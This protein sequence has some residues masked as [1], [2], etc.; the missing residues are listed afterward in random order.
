MSDAKRKTRQELEQQLAQVQSRLAF[1]EANMNMECVTEVEQLREAKEKMGLASMIVEKSPAVLFRR[2]ADDTFK[3]VYV[4]ENLSQW[5]YSAEDF[6]SGKHS[7]EDIVVAADN[8]R[9]HDEIMRYAELDVEEYTQEY[10]IRTA[11][12]QLRWVS[13]ETSV[14]RDE[15]GRRIFNQGVMLDI[16][17]RKEAEEALSANEFKFRRTIEG[18]GEGYLLLDGELVIK[19][20]NEA[21]CRMLGY[22]AE[23][24]LGRRPFDFATLEYQRYLE[25]R[26]EQFF[27]HERRRFE[28][29]MIHKDGH[30]VPVL[31]NA[32]TLLGRDGEFLG[33]VAFVADLTEQKKAV[34]L[35]GEVQKSLLP[36]RAPVIKGLDV[37]GSSMASDV[38][39]GDYF[40]YLTDMETGG[41]ALNVAVGDI[42]GHGVDAAL[43]MTTAR[44]FLRM[45][46]AQPGSPVQIVSEMNYHLAEDLDGSGRFMTLFYLRLDPEKQT[47]RWVRAGH[48]PAVIYCPTLDF[49][50]ELGADPGLPLGVVRET[51]Y[52]EQEN[53][54]HP[55]QIIAIGTDGIWEARNLTGEMFGKK[56][57]QEVLRANGGRTAQEILDAVFDAVREFSGGARP[58]DDIT[59]VIIKYEVE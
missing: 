52:S 19:E 59:L 21:Y 18:A 38:A 3:L 30:I 13:D 37:A 49:F 15:Q 20:V 27:K 6:L 22:E 45:R 23:E 43:L 35:A 48:D 36:S 56:R 11:D 12:G 57:Y 14:V 58:V 46:A 1:L 55:G 2:R 44:G 10:Q 9:L 26:K 24:L 25:S 42:S 54:L 17:R 40:D 33:N 4:S 16:T 32:N 34:T 31:V 47:A 8:S 7:F 39:G 51:Q 29:S 53:E 5:G 41:Q 28:G 50:T